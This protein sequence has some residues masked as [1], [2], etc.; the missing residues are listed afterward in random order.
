MGR[1]FFYVDYELL[2][3]LLKLPSDCTIENVAS[4]GEPYTIYIAV[5]HSGIPDVDGTGRPIQVKPRMEL[6][7][8]RISAFGGWGLDE[9]EPAAELVQVGERPRGG[10]ED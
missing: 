7:T 10:W 5:A 2:K 6:E 9:N 3:E 4:A 1:G 8:I